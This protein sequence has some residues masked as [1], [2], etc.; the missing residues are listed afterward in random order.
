MGLARSS[1]V[2]PRSALSDQTVSL[3]AQEIRRRVP[4]PKGLSSEAPISPK[5]LGTHGDQLTARLCDLPE[6]GG[7]AHL[8][9]APG[10][11]LPRETIVGFCERI[12]QSA[13]YT[14]RRAAAPQRTASE[15]CRVPQ[16]G[17]SLRIH[18]GLSP[19]SLDIG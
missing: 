4:F 1:D 12:E 9:A 16:P 8:A 5:T 6:V 19:R 3:R 7:R 14:V 15:T 11:H 18:S 17:V 2:S 10:L 13:L